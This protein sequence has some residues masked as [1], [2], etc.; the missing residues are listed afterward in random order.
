[1]KHVKTVAELDKEYGTQSDDET[2]RVLKRKGG[3][4]DPRARQTCLRRAAKALFDAGIGLNLCY[5]GLA[6]ALEAYMRAH[7]DKLLG[8]LESI[9]VDW[10]DKDEYMEGI[11]SIL[12]SE[13]ELFVP[14]FSDFDTDEPMM[15]RYYAALLRQRFGGPLPVSR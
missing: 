9:V 7:P 14:S 13:E 11:A 3:E 5:D 12:S 8:L 4:F 10:P 1:M 2:R 6:T 15:I